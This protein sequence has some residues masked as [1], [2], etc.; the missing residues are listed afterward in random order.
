MRRKHISWKTKCAA[1]LAALGH[2]RYD[3]LKKMTSH[4]FLTL[5]QWDHNILHAWEVADSDAYWNLTPML[6][7]AHREKTKHDVKLIAKSRRITKKEMERRQNAL[8][9][10]GNDVQRLGIDALVAEYDAWQAGDLPK[11][12]EL[13]TR[14]LKHRR[15]IPSRGF[16]KTRSR[17]LD[18]TVT[19]RRTT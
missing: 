18:G 15:K 17:H 2:I 16:D 7:K 10:F 12:A 14:R 1:A 19:P 11:A 6:I 4:Q 3:D 8:I 9:A 13:A 5:W